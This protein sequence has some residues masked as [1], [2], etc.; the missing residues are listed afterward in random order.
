MFKRLHVFLNS[1]AGLDVSKAK[2]LDV[3]KKDQFI[4]TM[5][6]TALLRLLSN[7]GSI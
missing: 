7:I 5:M 1:R 4:I 2:T 6:L 3:L